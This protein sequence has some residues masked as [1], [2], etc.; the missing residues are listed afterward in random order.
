MVHFNFIDFQI[1]FLLFYLEI[2]EFNFCHLNENTKRNI[3]DREQSQ[4][5]IDEE[6]TFRTESE[7]IIKGYLVSKDNPNQDE[8]MFELFEQTNED[9]D[10]N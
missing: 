10:D 7:I 8:K 2:L 1:I 4:S 3:R 9:N 5:S 6:E